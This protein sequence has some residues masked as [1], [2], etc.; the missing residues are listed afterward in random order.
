MTRW[1]CLSLAVIRPILESN[2]WIRYKVQGA[3]AAFFERAD[4]NHNGNE[5]ALAH[6][7]KIAETFDKGLRRLTVSPSGLR[8][9]ES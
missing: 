3:Y 8:P 5:Q 2:E 7:Q 4:Y 1:T 9:G 6:V